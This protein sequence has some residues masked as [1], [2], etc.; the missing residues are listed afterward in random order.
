[1]KNSKIITSFE[2]SN[3]LA[4]IAHCTD[5]CIMSVFWIMQTISGVQTWMSFALALLLGFAPL[6]L[7]FLSFK[8]DVETGVIKHSC[9]IG[10]ALFFTYTLFSSNN[11]QVFL[12]VLPMLLAISIY[13]DI[14]YSI[15]IN[16]G[17]IIE[18][19]IL[20]ILGLTTNRYGYD[21]IY[22]AII[23]VLAM[24]TFASDSFFT[25][26]TLNRNMESRL[27]KINAS[28]QKTEQLIQEMSNLSSHI[29]EEINSIY[30][31]LD[32]LNASAK[33]TQGAM[34][35]VSAGANETATAVQ[36]QTIQTQAI[37]EKVNQVD[38][39]AQD[40]RVHMQETMEIVEQ[41]NQAMH[42][43]VTLVGSSVS[44]SE[45]AAGKL[46]TL[47]HYMEEMNTIVELIKDITSQ[48]SLL[49]LNASIE[50]AR[51]GETGKGFAVVADEISGMA[52]RTK[53]ATIQITEL[54]GNV[55]IAIE[56]VV[57]VIKQMIQGI[58]EEKE[59]VHH[60]AENFTTIQKN[61]LFIQDS[62]HELT[63]NTSELHD[64]NQVIAD[65]VQTISAVSQ[66]LTAHANETMK[67]E[68]G[69]TE[70]LS[71][72]ADKMQALVALISQKS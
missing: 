70:I 16:I 56:E 13:G 67:A 46:D 59:S 2:R 48:T 37:Q 21:N 49:A 14:R 22:T 47:N 15:L 62:I 23:Q 1:M 71:S 53:D 25:T 58:S 61:S 44:N 72:I 32:Q 35:E 69:N 36:K 33:Q 31:S 30:H 63:L 43:L 40:I 64:S 27:S 8:K 11:H 34:I 60:T 26:R 52:T 57:S 50:A 66:E 42:T 20:V 3:R 68:S 17:V 10:F 51:A 6:V 65:S 5:V 19:F 24:L 18:L 4:M 45:Q 29:N 39:A 12:F 28:K 55:T 38:A 7:E 54:I 41:G 9:A